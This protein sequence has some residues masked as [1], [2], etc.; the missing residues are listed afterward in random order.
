MK[1]SLVTSKSFLNNKIFDD[2]CRDNVNRRFILLKKILED[3]DINISTYD[4][5]KPKE[6]Y[7]S[8]H[9]NVH[10]HTLFRQRSPKNILVVSESPI[11]CK[12]NQNKT[13]RQ[14]YDRVLSW[15]TKSDLDSALDWL[16]C[17]CSANILF[18]NSEKLSEVARKDLCI[19]CGNKFSND[20]GELYSERDHAIAYFCDSSVS[21]DMF[22]EGWGKRVFRG[23]LRPLNKVALFRKIF[24]QP[25]SCYKGSVASKFLTL[26]NYRFSLCFENVRGTNGYISEKI[27]D[28]MFSGCVPIYLGADDINIYVPA[29]TFI[30]MR[31]FDS[32]RDLENFIRL[33][34]PAQYCRYLDAIAD[35]YPKYLQ[36]SFHEKKW[37]ETIAKHC[38]EIVNSKV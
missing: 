34:E 19:I 16:G 24:Y 18:D 11:I 25:P 22:G 17:G 38:L 13:I 30:D 21:F 32:F 1:I 36:S 3:N 2:N 5:N 20:K 37:A 7:L 35:Y 33:M 28:S 10:K 15:E 8:L 29:N 26:A 27:F 9:F 6:C 12:A 31:D 4:I 14:Q 23:V